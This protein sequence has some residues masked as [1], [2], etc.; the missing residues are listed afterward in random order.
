MLIPPEELRMAVGP[1]QDPEVYARTA[2]EMVQ[3]MT[4]LAG[5]QPH[6]AVLDVGCGCGR[7][8]VALATF[9]EPRTSYDGI[10]VDG[11]AIR[12]CRENISKLYPRFRF[13][14]LDVLAPPYNLGGRLSPSLAVFPFADGSFDFAL[15]SSVFTH[16]LPEDTE[17]YLTET[18]RVLRN[19]GRSLMTFFLLNGESVAAIR[20]RTTIFDFSV[21]LGPCRTIDARTPTEALA[22]DEAFVVRLLGKIGFKIVPPVTYG[23]WRRERSYLISQDAIVVE[24][25]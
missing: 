24:K 21:D 6:H 13:H 20:D 17:R 15:A 2:T 19:G 3:S 14:V 4:R 1:F 10:D 23:S 12:W 25:A 8:A 22:Y 11:S 7:V 9:L 16:M 18:A 5:L